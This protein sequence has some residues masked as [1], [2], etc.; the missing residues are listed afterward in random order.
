MRRPKTPE[1]WLGL[2]CLLAIAAT[3]CQSVTRNKITPQSLDA[4]SQAK[5]AEGDKALSA[6]PIAQKQKVGVHL[7]LGRAFEV[8]GNFEAALAEYQ[9][10][11]QAADE[12]GPRFGDGHVT[13]QQKALAERRMGGALDRMGRFSLAEMHYRKALELNPND[14]NVWND[15]GYSYYLQK[16][17][18]DAERC[19]LTAARFEPNNQR[20]QTN[21][22][23]TL[24]ALGKTDAALAALT[25]AANPAAAHANL[26]YILAAIGKPDEA[27]KHYETALAIQPQFEAARYALAALDTGGL[28]RANGNLPVAPLQAAAAGARPTS[29]ASVVVPPASPLAAPAPFAPAPPPP[30]LAAAPIVVPKPIAVVAAGGTNATSA[31]PVASRAGLPTPPVPV[32]SVPPARTAAPRSTTSA[33]APAL[34]P[35]LSGSPARDWSANPNDPLPGPKQIM[36]APPTALAS[37]TSAPRGGTDP[38]S[39][40]AAST[41]IPLPAVSSPRRWVSDDSLSRASADT[42]IPLPRPQAPSP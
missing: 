34:V 27:R 21:L 28:P 7:D 38:R 31:P 16:R 1:A 36:T 33:H 30:S 23:L 40:A 11:L 4:A 15:A 29:M 6:G 24:A 18:P 2:A 32:A 22:G 5:G 25:R 26:G 41:G 20:V 13:K 37:A 19:L 42:G 3:G 14:A 39:L 9:K 8:Q 35:V 12:P 10:A 17:W